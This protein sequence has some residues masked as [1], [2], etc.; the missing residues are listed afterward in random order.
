MEWNTLS[1]NYKVIAVIQCIL[2]FVGSYTSILVTF[3]FGWTSI[4]FILML[5]FSFLVLLHSFYLFKYHEKSATI[6]MTIWLMQSFSF[7]S[8]ALSFSF[9]IGY[10]LTIGI[11]SLRINIFAL[12][13]FIWLCFLAFKKRQIVQSNI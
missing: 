8:E 7:K 13:I 3:A 10:A 4:F 5:L 6:A 1:N 2:I 12:P 9:C 11:G